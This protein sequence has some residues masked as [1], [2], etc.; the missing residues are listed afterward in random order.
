MNSNDRGHDSVAHQ[1]ADRLLFDAEERMLRMMVQFP[2]ARL[3]MQQATSNRDFLGLIEW[4][5]PEREWLFHCLTNS[6]PYEELPQTMF[7][8][9]TPSQLLQY[10]RDR[11]DAPYGAFLNSPGETDELDKTNSPGN[12]ETLK[13]LRSAG[14]L[15]D[16]RIDSWHDPHDCHSDEVLGTLEM[17]FKK[18]DDDVSQIELDETS[19]SHDKNAPL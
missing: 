2:V 7:E 12:D 14:N 19:V 3:A 15:R 9:G 17:F 5:T 10:L 1:D 6:P 8:C 18:E 16:V 4:S 13:N 11:K